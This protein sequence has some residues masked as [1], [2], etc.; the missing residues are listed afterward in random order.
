MSGSGIMG[1]CTRKDLEL[2]IGIKKRDSFCFLFLCFGFL[3]VS[4]NIIKLKGGGGASAPKYNKKAVGR[5]WR[6]YRL[7]KTK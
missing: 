6:N 3:Y 2:S 4:M 1:C 5:S 7:I